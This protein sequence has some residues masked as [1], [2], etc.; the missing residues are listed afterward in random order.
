VVI[1]VFRRPDRFSGCDLCELVRCDVSDPCPIWPCLTQDIEVG[2][3]LNARMLMVR[4]QEHQGFPG[5]TPPELQPDDDDTVGVA[6]RASAASPGAA[7]PVPVPG[8][9]APGRQ[10][11]AAHLHPQA[12]PR[13]AQP[14]ARGDGLPAG[15][16]RAAR[17]EP[18][19][20][21]PAGRDP[22]RAGVG[23]RHGGRARRGRH[24]LPLHAP[25]LRAPPGRARGARLGGRRLL[26]QARAAAR[27]RVPRVQ[28]GARG[29]LA[30]R[31][32]RPRQHRS[33]EPLGDQQ[34]R[35]VGDEE[36]VHGPPERHR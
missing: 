28:G 21:D 5:A 30:G 29:E 16:V 15:R 27:P 26:R 19:A 3:I 12:E 17:D 31:R 18:A 10:A 33:E 32:V 2:E 35:L 25:G 11:E 24:P 9:P 36:S 20:A 34:P 1:D 22:R 7:V 4:R 23:G 8:V 6:T 14:P 13:A